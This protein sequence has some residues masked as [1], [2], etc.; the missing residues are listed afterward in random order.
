M[1]GVVQKQKERPDKV[2]DIQ[3]SLKSQEQSSLSQGNSFNELIVPWYCWYP[4]YMS[5][6]YSRM[7]MQSYY[8]RYPSIYPSRISQIPI[9]NNLVRKK[10]NCSNKC[11]KDIKQ[12]L[13]YLKPRWCPSGLS[14][15]QKR[16]LQ[17]LRKKEPMEQQVEATPER[18]VNMKKVWW[19]KQ[20]V[21]TST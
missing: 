15:A 17:C 14:H 1:K 4:C 9:R 11:E 16:R 6:D 18:S 12:D 21:S 10:L 13:K 5:L 2:E 19:P 7:H 20:I 8:I 3:L